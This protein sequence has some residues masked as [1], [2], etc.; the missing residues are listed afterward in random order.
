MFKSIVKIAFFCLLV[1]L[2]V[3]TTA[4]STSKLAKVHCDEIVVVIDKDSP[5]FIDEEEIAALVK[6]AGGNLLNTRLDSINTE[7][8]EA[9][10][11]KVTAIKNIEI[12][13]RVTGEDMDFKG[14]LMVEVKQRQPILRVINEKENFYLDDEG[15]RIP[16]NQGVATQV[17]LVNGDVSEKYAREE[18]LPMVKFIRSDEFW[19]AQ[20]EQLQVSRQ[21]D[22]IMA[23][24]VGDQI[25]ELGK[26]V[27]FQIKFRNLRALYDQAF[28]KVGWEYYSK[29][30]LKYTNQVVCT[31][32]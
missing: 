31:K 24:L 11:R 8:L 5:R 7:K 32:K 15:V 26:T 30:N 21:G 20:I 18:L 3:V 4:F 6:K 27:D 29:I 25:I 14:R 10:L 23:P 2:V 28:S 12:Y 9:E 1:A 17:L 16:A 22:V 19:N 13:R